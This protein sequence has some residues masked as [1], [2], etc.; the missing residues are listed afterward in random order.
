[1]NSNHQKMLMN[2]DKNSRHYSIKMDKYKH[3][4]S[5]FA[6]SNFASPGLLGNV[7]REY[8]SKPEDDNTSCVITREKN[9]VDIMISKIQKIQ[10]K[11][12]Y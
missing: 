9:K 11:K 7:R 3:L 8:G 6:L 2:L 1:M 10:K 5:N 4:L 12:I